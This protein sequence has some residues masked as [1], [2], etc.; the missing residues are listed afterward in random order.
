MI[1]TVLR[2]VMATVLLAALTGLVYPLLMTA[3]AQSVFH[4]RANGSLVEVNG[5][6]VGSSLIGQAWTGPA[7]FYGRP[8]ATGDDASTSGGSNLGPRSQQLADEIEQRAAAIVALESPYEPEVATSGIPV[9][10]LT[11]SASGLDPHISVEAARFQVPRIAAVRG[12]TTGQVDALIDSYTQQP[13]L[14]VLGQARVNVL[15]LNAA[16]EEI[17]PRT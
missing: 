4:D 3:F 6:P 14:G 11:A 15:E 17:A 12:L 10:L 9:D 13:T 5:Q 16:L 8:S 1:K 7:W 2:A